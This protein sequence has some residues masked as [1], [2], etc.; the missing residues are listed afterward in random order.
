MRLVDILLPEYAREIEATAAT[1]SQLPGDGLGWRPE[2]AARS[3]GELISHLAEITLW[4][5]P[6]LRKD[7]IDL[8][9]RRLLTAATTLA[10]AQTQFQTAAAEGRRAL[11]EKID[12][13]LPADWTLARG[14]T[15]LF[16]VP[17]VTALRILVLNHL[18][19]HRGQLTFYLRSLGASVPPLYGPTR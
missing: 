18:I 5:D 14:G 1:L 8:D 11:V 12:S 19:H 7:K 16:V 13:E 9:D 17:R 2:P 4:A 10:E 3:A 15:P 6:I